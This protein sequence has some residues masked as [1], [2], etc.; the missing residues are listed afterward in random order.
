[1][2]LNLAV[3]LSSLIV[4]GCN[5]QIQKDNGLAGE[6]ASISSTVPTIEAKIDTEELPSST[7]EDDSSSISIKDNAVTPPVASSDVEVNWVTFEKAVELNKSDPRKML[8]DI[9]TDWCGWCKKMDRDTY[10]DERIV[11]II[12]ENFYAIKFNAEQREPITFDDHVFEYQSVGRRGVHELAAALTQNKLSYPTTVF[13]DEQIRI[14]QPLPGYLNAN[15][16]LPI[17]E[18]IGL[19]HFKSTSWAEFQKS[20]Q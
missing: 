4:V 11:K 6:V 10:S 7:Y 12:N 19:D 13:M 20:Y 5:Q 3:V 8:I 1:M 9:Y 18:F 17:L 14:I 16:M 15:K 2:K